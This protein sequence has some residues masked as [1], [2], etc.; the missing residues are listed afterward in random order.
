MMIN[1]APDAISQITT[2]DRLVARRCA[3]TAARKS[4]RELSIST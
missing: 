4:A 1:I 2:P 3:F